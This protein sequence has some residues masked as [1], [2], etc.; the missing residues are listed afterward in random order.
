MMRQLYIGMIGH[1]WC[2]AVMGYGNYNAWQAGKDNR[3]LKE[4][5]GHG[6]RIV[7]VCGWHILR[8]SMVLSSVGSIIECVRIIMASF[9]RYWV[10]KWVNLRILSVQSLEAHHHHK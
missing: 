9:R 7:S 2:L 5:E 4:Y 10:M 6:F 3:A 1:Q 8:N